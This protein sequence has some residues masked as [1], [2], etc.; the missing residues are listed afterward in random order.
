MPDALRKWQESERDRAE[1]ETL[2]EEVILCVFYRK[3]I[4]N[5]FFIKI[6]EYQ[7][8]EQQINE[9]LAAKENELNK[10]RIEKNKTTLTLKK[11]GEKWVTV[12]EE[13]NAV[14]RQQDIAEVRNILLLLF[15]FYFFFFFLT[16]QNNIAQ[17][18][19][20]IHLLEKELENLKGQIVE[21]SETIKK[22]T[23]FI[24]IFL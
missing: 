14:T 18:N 2:Q 24:L 4:L 5:N 22:V 16:K 6:K 15:I 7:N 19:E 23:F 10:L 9:T 3:K 11:M 8:A 12:K 13:L 21:S 1:I 20:T 17:N